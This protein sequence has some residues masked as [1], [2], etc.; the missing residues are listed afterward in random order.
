MTSV[1]VEVK[2]QVAKQ[3][4]NA[5]SKDG[6]LRTLPPHLI[7]RNLEKWS[8]NVP[9]RKYEEILQQG[10]PHYPEE[11]YYTPKALEEAIVWI[12]RAVA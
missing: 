9:P 2:L 10:G 11:A 6:L 1:P 3:V 5:L 12:G 4:I 7:G 8:Q